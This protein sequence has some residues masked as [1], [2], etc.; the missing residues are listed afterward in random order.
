MKKILVILGILL[1]LLYSG[2]TTGN[3]TSSWS[4]EINTFSRMSMSYKNFNGYK[5]TKITVKAGEPVN[6]NAEFVSEEG[7]IGLSITDQDGNSFYQGTDIPTSS[8]AVKLDKKGEYTIKVS[9]ENHKGEYK[10]TW[11]REDKDKDK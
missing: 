1:M 4:K 11:S 5:Q 6:V 8:F 10:I 2:C 7:K 9:A 3:Y